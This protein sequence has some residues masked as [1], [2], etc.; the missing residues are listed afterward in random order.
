[1]ACGFSAT[2]RL[3]FSSHRIPPDIRPTRHLFFLI[4]FIAISREHPRELTGELT[5]EAQ[6]TW[7]G[8]P[9]LL[10][11]AAYSLKPPDRRWAR[12]PLPL[13]LAPGTPGPLKGAKI[14]LRQL[15]REVIVSG[16][17]TTHSISRSP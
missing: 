11:L 8:F 7:P 15:H 5:G 4:G 12:C 14:C 3:Y 13:L 2:W 10:L 17:H 1:M 9:F 16:S 6:A